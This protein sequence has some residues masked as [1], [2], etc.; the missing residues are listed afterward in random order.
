MG[1]IVTVPSLSLPPCTF[2]LEPA[3]SLFFQNWFSKSSNVFKNLSVLSFILTVVLKKVLN[4]NQVLVRAFS[5]FVLAALSI[6][7]LRYKQIYTRC[8]VVLSC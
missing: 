2:F 8:F 5:D 4:V 6:T 1:D 3:D 7:A